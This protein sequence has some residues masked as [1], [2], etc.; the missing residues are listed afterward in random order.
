[1]PL[2]A[3][4]TKREKES[5]LLNGE[6]KHRTINLK[7]MFAMMSSPKL[8]DLF[9]KAQRRK[10]EKDQLQAVLDNHIETLRQYKFDEKYAD[11][12]VDKLYTNVHR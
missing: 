8:C 3:E 10:Y 9:Y 4:C 5:Q 6:V 1:M 7:V 11:E 2:I 12:Y